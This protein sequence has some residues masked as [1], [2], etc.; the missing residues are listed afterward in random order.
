MILCVHIERL[1]PRLASLAALMDS[2]Q[3]GEPEFPDA[4]LRWLDETEKTM[5]S[6]RLTEA[7]ELSALRGT[8]LKTKDDLSTREKRPARSAIRSA[9]NAA[10]V[11]ALSRAEEFVRERVRESEHR[12][13]QFEE[14]LCE[15]MTALLLQVALPNPGIEGTT[16]LRQTWRL[17]QQQDCTKA[18][19]IYLD[20]SLSMV[21]RL[22]LLDRVLGRLEQRDAGT[23]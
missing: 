20:A 12:L 23:E 19:A 3:R 1:G 4:A 9:R 8:V 2:Y 18:L 14:K 11:D 15:G 6:L 16:R 21:D 7:S 10:A 13:D 22:Y 17:L 5:A